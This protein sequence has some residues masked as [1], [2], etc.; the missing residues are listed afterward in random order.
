ML[1]IYFMLSRNQL[2]CITAVAV[3]TIFVSCRRQA[4][5]FQPQV[6]CIQND[7]PVTGPALLVS[8]GLTRVDYDTAVCGFLPMHKDAYWIYTDSFFNSSGALTLVSFDTIRVKATY[9]SPGSP[10][11]FWQFSSR[12]MKGF[13]KI[14]YTTDSMVY[15]ITGAFSLPS[16]Y[17]AYP[18]AGYRAAGYPRTPSPN[19]GPSN[20]DTLFTMNFLVDVGFPE[21][22]VN[23][24]QPITVPAGSYSDCMGFSKFYGSQISEM[25]FKP[26]LGMVQYKRF[27]PPSSYGMY[28]YGTKQQVSVLTSYH[29]F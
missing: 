26:G 22:I 20:N 5:F 15:A 11:V 23:Y 27:Y 6:T 28:S 9:K 19:F 2:R 14:M 21:K 3:L 12:N 29:L 16:F 25:V 8:S 7:I 4:E 1:Y 24:R 13:D 18:W 10:S 17:D